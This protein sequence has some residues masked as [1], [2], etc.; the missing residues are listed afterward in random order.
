MTSGSTLKLTNIRLR[1]IP[2]IVGSRIRVETVL[3]N[4]TYAREKR[5]LDSLLLPIQVHDPSEA[6]RSSEIMPELAV[7]YDVVARRDYG[8][9]I[10]SIIYGQVEDTDAMTEH[11]IAEEEKLLR[12]GMEP[13]LSI[14]IA[15]PKRGIAGAVARGRYFLVPKL[16]RIGRELRKV[17]GR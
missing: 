2:E 13:F 17:A 7:G 11:L 3:T 8:G 16:K 1:I 6:I 14:I 12:D 15:K 5:T 9:N 10:L 4:T